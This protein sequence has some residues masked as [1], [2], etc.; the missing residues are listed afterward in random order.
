MAKPDTTKLKE[1][2]NTAKNVMIFLPENPHF[3]A[4]AAALSLKLSLQT[5]GKSVNVLCPEEITVEFNRLVGVDSITNSFGPRHLV[6][7]FP[8]QTDRVD[9]VSYNVENGELQLVITPKADAPDLDHSKLKFIAHTN[10]SDLAILVGVHQLL[11]LGHFF[12]STRDFFANTKLISFTVDLPQE[13]YTPHQIYDP[14]ASSL[15]EITLHLLEALELRVDTDI[16]TNLLTGMEKATDNFSSPDVSHATFETAAKLMRRGARR[17]K[18]I[19]PDSFPPGS[20]PQAQ[21]AP[22][23]E[24]DQDVPVREAPVPD[25]ASPDW[26]QPK[27][28]S[29]SMI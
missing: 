26:Y 7:S 20:I 18:V 23:P 28:Y 14:N 10:H 29:G 17:G 12:H 8:G 19:N 25:D 24:P 22:V 21:A 3:D 27:V 5:I 15:S 16:A 13:N 9:K 6:I 4:V 1:L 2:I 11:D